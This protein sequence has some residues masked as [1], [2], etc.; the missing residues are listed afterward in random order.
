MLGRE[1]ELKFDI[2]PGGAGRIAKTAPLAGAPGERTRYETL[3]FDTADAALRRAGYSLRIRRSGDRYV[4]TIKRKKASSA[5][6]FVRQEWEE[7][8]PDFTLRADLLKR[9]PL[10]RWAARAEAGEILPLIRSEITRSAWQVRHRGSRIE[11]VLDRGRI[12][13]GKDEA[14]IGE[15][16]LELIRGRPSA[17]FELA[18]GFG[19][20]TAL[21]L[22]VMSKS[23][24]G[25][26][27]AEGRLGQA[28]KAERPTLTPSATA[29]DA[30]STTAHACLRHFR[31]NEMVLL[32]REDPEALHQARVALRR[33]RSAMRL[34][35]PA[36]NG[37]DEVRLR[38]ELRWF[39]HHFGEA[40]NLSVLIERLEAAKIDEA[41]IAPL[42]EAHGKA[43]RQMAR[44]LRSK[45]T[46]TLFLELILWIET[47]SWR[48]GP[49][50]SADLGALANEQLEQRWKQV[51]KR[52]QGFEAQ[53]PEER[54]ELRIAVKAMRYSAEFL[55]PLYGVKP[56]GPRRDRFIGALKKL[57][58]RLGDLN[59]AWT[60]EQ[61]AERLPAKLRDAI[62]AAHPP[63][64][65]K[66]SLAVAAKA[67]ERAE[68]AAGYWREARP[69]V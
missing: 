47:G 7:E 4:Q 38:G 58:D 26:A 24:R 32:D 34:F 54:H 13:S 22:G 11:V 27:L 8:V 39:A 51:A 35:R 3:Y 66:A 12:C 15:L 52:A 16:E 48:A 42:R 29:A 67:L 2:E 23:E 33:L 45:R 14:P 44:A 65:N 53:H 61:L 46:R 10:R 63:R 37:K 6:L 1:V 19:E 9:T 50:A 40:R 17:L 49:R 59:D 69:A 41:V 56:M 28:A 57:Q 5:G 20:K 25:Y 68:A 30:F 18:C 62:V 43:H 55:A 36:L 64:E 31:L 21:R 60:A